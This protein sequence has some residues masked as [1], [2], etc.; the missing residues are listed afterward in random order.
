MARLKSLTVSPVLVASMYALVMV[1]L[2]QWRGQH[3]ATG[4]RLSA[5]G[6][7]SLVVFTGARFAESHDR[8]VR[9][10]GMFLAVDAAAGAL[11][12][13]GLAQ[14][15]LSQAWNNYHF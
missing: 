12:V 3:S 4:G 14:L 1:V 6:I 13:L 15:D 10:A 9:V 8:T 2:F 11:Y 7:S 5:I